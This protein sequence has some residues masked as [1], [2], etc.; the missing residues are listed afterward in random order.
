MT[1]WVPDAGLP[2]YDASATTTFFPDMAQFEEDSLPEAPSPPT[3]LPQWACER[4]GTLQA[5]LEAL[6]HDRDSRRFN[7]RSFSLAGFLSG[8]LVQLANEVFGFNG[9]STAVL[10]VE[11]LGSE[12]SEEKFSASYSAVVRLTLRDGTFYDASGVGTATNLP[13]R[14]MCVSKAKKQAVT[15]GIK[16]AIVGLKEVFLLHEMERLAGHYGQNCK[17]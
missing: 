9:W 11:P 17:W 2:Q 16:N 4:I 5:R 6:Q 12:N 13:H 10:Q 15:E 7:V 1:A 3:Q 14:Y 8:Q